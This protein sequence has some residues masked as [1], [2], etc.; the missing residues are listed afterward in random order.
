MSLKWGTVLERAGFVLRAC[1]LWSGKEAKEA[2]TRISFIFN[3]LYF[4]SKVKEKLEWL[5]SYLN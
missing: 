3:P 4:R 5:E 2:G 1:V